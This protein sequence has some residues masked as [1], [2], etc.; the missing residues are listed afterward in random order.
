MPRLFAITTAF[1]SVFLDDDRT[2][3]T[4]FTV[5]NQSG[6]EI[7]GRARLIA[8]DAEAES[9]ITLQGNPQRRFTTAGTE[10]YDVAIDVPPDA[11][12]ASYNF[13]LDMVGEERPDEQYVEG[14]TITFQVPEAEPETEAFPWRIV[15][16]I[17]A[18]L[19]LGGGVLAYGLLSDNGEEDMAVVPD[20]SELTLDRALIRLQEEALFGR[21]STA[22]SDTVDEGLIIRTEPPAGDTVESES[23]VILLRS[24]GPEI[25]VALEQAEQLSREWMVAYNQ[26]N[27]EKLVS[28]ASPPFL[29]DTLPVLTTREAIRDKFRNVDEEYEVISFEAMTISELARRLEIQEEPF[30]QQRLED[31]RMEEDDVGVMV[32]DAFLIFF[33]REGTDV[34]LAGVAR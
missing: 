7:E 6:R 23:E 29:F 15:A 26:S 14:P 31:L 16:V 27:V 10:Q 13:R 4:S 1:N 11:P 5:S 28:L 9:W 25:E 34:E 33:R 20:V 18:V 21:D 19:L 22:F 12:S 24:V 30:W 32:H 2:A 3:E 17:A 8:E